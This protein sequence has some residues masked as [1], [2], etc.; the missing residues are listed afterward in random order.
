MSSKNKNE[1]LEIQPNIT[2]LDRNCFVDDIKQP[3]RNLKALLT[4]KFESKN[5]GSN[6]MN[7]IL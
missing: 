3:G 4:R 1:S 5:T 7:D 6:R 2:I